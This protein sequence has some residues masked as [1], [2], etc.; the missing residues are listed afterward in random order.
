VEVELDAVLVKLVL[1][2]LELDEDDTLEELLGT[3]PCNVLL[4]LVELDEGDVPEDIKLELDRLL[5]VVVIKVLLAAVDAAEKLEVDATLVVEPLEVDRVLLVGTMLVELDRLDA[6]LV[7][8]GG[9]A[10]ELVLMLLDPLLEEELRDEVELNVMLVIIDTMLMEAE[11]EEDNEL[12]LD[13]PLVVE[14]KLE[15][16]ERVDVI[17]VKLEDD[18]DETKEL[19]VIL[20]VTVLEPEDSEALVDMLVELGVAEIFGVL[21]VGN[22]D[23]SDELGLEL[24]EEELAKVLELAVSDEI[25]E[26]EL[27]EIVPIPARTVVLPLALLLLDPE[28]EEVLKN[29]VVDGTP[30]VE[31]LVLENWNDIVLLMVE[32]GPAMDELCVLLDVVEG[33]ITVV[34]L[35]MMFEVVDMLELL[36]D[37]PVLDPVAGPETLVGVVH[38]H[39]GARAV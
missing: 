26:L 36:L 10:V 1:A 30:L 18:T 15:D 3:A 29:V 12:V 22:I 5:N 9:T 31:R 16:N 20:D 19:E 25:V 2:K 28:V 34:V 23:D 17:L 33:E 7:E 24:I 27:L 21:V 6:M 8:L 32:D 39:I 14:I 38:L 11:L 13:R 4:P 35:A 37:G